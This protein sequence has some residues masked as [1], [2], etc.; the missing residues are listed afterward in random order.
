M[1]VVV[2]LASCS[3][4]PD[5][6]STQGS[7]TSAPPTTVTTTTPTA[8]PTTPTYTPPAKRGVKRPAGV[9][10]VTDLPCMS[11]NDDA[12]FF[13]LGWY[14]DLAKYV[15]QGQ[16]PPDARWASAAK[17]IGT[18]RGGIATARAAL[19]ADGVPTSYLAYQDLKELDAAMLA[20]ISAARKRD[21]SQVMHVYFAVK[22]AQA[23]LV[24]S[25][26]ALER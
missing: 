14:G 10:P 16:S 2:L 18:F 15:E 9:T 11:A 3:G 7:T 26:G 25:C 22:T 23:H 8:P 17:N 24:E 4:S 19:Q 20:G 5:P 21:E 1:P 13:Q 12:Q 6:Q